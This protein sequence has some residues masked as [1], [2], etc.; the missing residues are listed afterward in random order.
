MTACLAPCA[1]IW[2]PVTY[3]RQHACIHSRLL[4]P[5]LPRRWLAPR[6]GAV[7]D[8]TFQLEV[9][10]QAVA[11]LLG[12]ELPS[13]VL[14]SQAAVPCMPALRHMAV[15]FRGR[16]E[17]SFAPCPALPALRTLWMANMRLQ[18]DNQHA[19]I[20]GCFSEVQ[21]LEFGM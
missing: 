15:N 5:A 8:L 21:G 11:R 16:A 6:V 7:A 9:Q 13:C 2:Q 4:P 12:L 14:P 17:L 18:W 20:F 19:R 10:S 1:Y 3:C